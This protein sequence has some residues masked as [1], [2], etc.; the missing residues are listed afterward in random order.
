MT[1]FEVYF[2][3]VLIHTNWHFLVQLC[4]RFITF[5]PKIMTNALDKLSS[6]AYRGEKGVENQ[7][8]CRV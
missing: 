6:L 4:L 1:V 7:G 8:G 5:A 2:T 3:S